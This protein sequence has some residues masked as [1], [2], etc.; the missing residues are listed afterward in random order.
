VQ[1]LIG[2]PYEQGLNYNTTFDQN[3]YLLKFD[4]NL[5]TKNHFSLRDNYTNFENGNNQG[6]T[7]HLSNQ[8]VEHDKFNQL[9]GQGETIFTNNFFN[10]FIAQSVRMGG[11]SYRT[12]RARRFR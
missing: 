9:V 2:Y 8:G 7:T 5:G 3:T 4:A 6:T 12:A 1:S 11:R 10:Q